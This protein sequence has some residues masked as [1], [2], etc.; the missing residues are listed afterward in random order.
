MR[1]QELRSALFGLLAALALT[2]TPAEP[3]PEQELRE[4][5]QAI[6]AAIEEKDPEAVL[7]HIAFDYRGDGGLGYPEV[8]AVVLTFL[9]REETIGARLLE[10]SIEPADASG[11]QRVQA[12]VAFARGTRLARRAF[13]HAG[14]E[15]FFDLVF[16][17]EDEQWKAVRGRYEP[18]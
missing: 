2:C 5:A 17:R 14:V 12:R 3:A 18:L 1:K 7:R 10:L 15:Y 13:P 11:N 6:V 9:L 16:A 8:Q 4:V